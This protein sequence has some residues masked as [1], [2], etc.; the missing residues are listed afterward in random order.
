VEVDTLGEFGTTALFDGRI[1]YYIKAGNTRE[2]TDVIVYVEFGTT[3]LFEGR[4]YV[5]YRL[6]IRQQHS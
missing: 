5:I 2:Y 1:V 3:A 4:L 6:Y